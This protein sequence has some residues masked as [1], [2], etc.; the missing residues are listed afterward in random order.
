VSGG[1]SAA[2]AQR[3]DRASA[4]RT[5]ARFWQDRPVLSDLDGVLLD[6]DDTLF[7]HRT[8]ADQAAVAWAGALPGWQDRAEDA[9]ARWLALE[10]EHFPRYARGE[11]T[12]L[13]QRRIR[14]RAFHPS[15]AALD[16]AAIDAAFVDYLAFYESYWRALPGASSLVEGL[17]ASGLKVGIL[18]NGYPDQQQQKLERTGLFRADVPI[19]ASAGLGVAKPSPQAFQLACAGLGTMPSR[20]LMVGDNYEFDVV[21]ARTAGLPAMF[22][23]RHGRGVEPGSPTSLDGVAAAILR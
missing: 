4:V 8:A 3:R 2:L 17:L 1:E 13:E 10:N 9:V 16:D 7:D 21:A 6:L 5:S 18:T 22:F 11:L 20:T 15:L 12:L 19:F 14:V 23:D